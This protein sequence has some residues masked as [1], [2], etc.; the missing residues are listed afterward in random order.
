MLNY[1]ML[2]GKGENVICF[3][4]NKRTEFHFRSK[5]LSIHTTVIAETFTFIDPYNNSK[6]TKL[7]NI[8]DFL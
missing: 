3:V 7:V 2:K 1:E 6:I 8:R 4:I 5:S